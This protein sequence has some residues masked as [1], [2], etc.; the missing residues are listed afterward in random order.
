MVAE[1]VK[2]W[3]LEAEFEKF[4]KLENNLEKNC[5][6]ETNFEKLA[7]LETFLEKLGSWNLNF[8][9]W[10]GRREYEVGDNY[11]KMGEVKKKIE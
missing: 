7:E 2:S 10:K 4:C 3:K 8:R 1:F 5:K 11:R 9:I 6:L